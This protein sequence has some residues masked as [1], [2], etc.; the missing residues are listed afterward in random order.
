MSLSIDLNWSTVQ[1]LQPFDEMN[2]TCFLH[3]YLLLNFACLSFT[4]LATGYIYYTLIH[5]KLIIF[6]GCCLFNP[7]K[8]KKKWLEAFCVLKKD[9]YWQ[10]IM[11]DVEYLFC[12]VLHVQSILI[13]V[14]VGVGQFKI[15]RVQVHYT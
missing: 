3:A 6:E 1:F 11:C 8:R 12:I 10:K 7:L 4:A 5:N 9:K 15:G 13:F 2:K 14:F